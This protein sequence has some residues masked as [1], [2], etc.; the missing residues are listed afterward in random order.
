LTS[1]PESGSSDLHSSLGEIIIIQHNPLQYGGLF[2]GAYLTLLP[3]QTVL[4][5]HHN[6]LLLLLL[7]MMMMMMMMILL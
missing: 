6:S 1:C 5:H 4:E 2:C 3:E 7:M